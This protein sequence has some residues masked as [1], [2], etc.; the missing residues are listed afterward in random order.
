LDLYW[1]RFD[2]SKKAPW[3]AREILPEFPQY[4]DRFAAALRIALMSG[5][6]F[7]AKALNDE[8]GDIAQVIDKVMEVVLSRIGR[9]P[10]GHRCDF[11]VTFEEALKYGALMMCSSLVSSQK[12][13]GVMTTTIENVDPYNV[14]LDPTGR[15]FYRIRQIEMDINAFQSLKHAKDGKGKSLWNV[16]EIGSATSQ[17]L[18]AVSEQMARAEREK[19]TGTAQFAASNRN[20]IV[21]WEFYGTI[22]DNEGNTIGENVLAI[23]ANNTWLVR[24]PEKNPFWHGRDWLVTAPILPV[25]GAPYGRAY[26]ENFA[27]IAKTLNELTNLLLDAVFTSSMKAFAV[28]PS[29]LEDP[30]QIEEGVYPNVVF[31]LQ[32]GNLPGDFLKEVN[33]G[34]LP[35]DA[36][37]FWQMLKKELQE[38]AAF[39]D[40]SLGGMAAHSRTSATEIGTAEQNSNSLI[41]SIAS[42]VECLFMEPLLDIVWRTTIQHLDKNDKE[43][44]AAVGDEWF[45]ALYKGKKE[46]AELQVTFICRGIS[47]LIMKQQKLQGLMQ[48]M[49]VIG[50]NQQLAGAFQ[51]KVNPERFFKYINTLFGIETVNIFKTPREEQVAKAQ[52]DQ[53]MQQQMQ[54]QAQMQKQQMLMDAVAKVGASAVKQPPT[55]DIG[56]QNISQGGAG[57]KKAPGQPSAGA[58]GGQAIPS[59]GG[60]P[61]AAQQQL[62][63]G[64]GGVG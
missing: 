2:Y 37:T 24:G 51:E 33:L 43:I 50:Q 26:V 19:R 39:N 7:N 52:Q 18:Q 42:N 13:N 22:I 20:V 57:A 15:N 4:V 14:W 29:A 17:A 41:Q 25:P 64:A 49:Q 54:Q 10:S 32:D 23:W 56:T 3:Q 34:Q 38:G 9:T 1:N 11:L 8:E 6:F 5:K 36:A 30:T 60:V 46:F 47:S 28:V 55:T 53:Q 31:R 45:D 61:A 27:S 16:E 58:S 21:L 63:T 12:V 40:I 62:T 35:P 48:Y 59:G 44:R